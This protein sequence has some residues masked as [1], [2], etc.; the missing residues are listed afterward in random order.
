MWTTYWRR[1]HSLKHVSSSLKN[2]TYKIGKFWCHMFPWKT[3][4][5]LAR[6]FSTTLYLD[7]INVKKA[8]GKRRMRASNF[9]MIFLGAAVG[10]CSV[11][12]HVG[13]CSFS[14]IKDDHS[15]WPTYTVVVMKET[16]WLSKLTNFIPLGLGRRSPGHEELVVVYFC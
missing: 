16:L 6:I 11:L 13:R 15:Y 7:Y 12:C 3:C 10:G 14:S 5:F 1:S 4:K 9:L 8:K 2:A